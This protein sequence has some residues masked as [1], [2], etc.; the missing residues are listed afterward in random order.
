METGRHFSYGGTQMEVLAPFA[1][2]LPAE[3]PKNND[4]LVLR[5]RYGAR[6]FL[7]SGDVEKPIERR[8]V[9]E[10][11]VA[12]VDVLKVA[13]H[14]SHTSSTEEFLNAAAPLFAIISVGLE[15]SYGHPHRDVLERMAQHGVTVYRTDADGAVTIL[16]DGRRL[17]IETGRD[18][19]SGLAPVAAWE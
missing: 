18:E 7:L 10:N 12:P 4:S 6:S 8:M 15:N 16:T 1:D 5:L 14:G 9:D 17:R 11:E 13:H 3:I 2:Y 19:A